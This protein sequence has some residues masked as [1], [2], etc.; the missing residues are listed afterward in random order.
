[1][2]K[3][4]Q[5]RLK[6]S[7]DQKKDL[8]S[9][10]ELIDEQFDKVLTPS[11][12]KQF[13]S[14]F[15]PAGPPPA[16]SNPG[17]PTQPGRILST[18]QQDTLKLSPAQRKRLEE[19]QKDIDT[20]LA[21][22]LTEEQKKQLQA[23]QRGVAVGPGGTGRGGP[24]AGGAPLFRAVRYPTNYAGFAGRQLLPG[25]TLDE[26]QAKESEKKKPQEKN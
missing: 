24:P 16:V 5:D 25:K 13:K 6:L 1:M 14:V 9:L 18:A 8:D 19:I 26:T 7:D 20:R 10:Q 4:E 23:M 17:G 12:R 21:T 22:L 15:A 3:V 2:A 11:Q